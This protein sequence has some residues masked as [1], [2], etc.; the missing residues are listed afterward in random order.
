M[1]IHRHAVT[2]VWKRQLW[3]LRQSTR[4]RIRTRFRTDLRQSSVCAGRLLR[5]KHQRPRPGS[6]LYAMAHGHPHSS[7]RY[8]VLGIG[9][10]TGTEEQ[11]L[12]LPITEVDIIIGKWLA[13]MSYFSLALICSLSN[14]AVLSW[15]GE[16]DLGL[17][18][19]QYFD[20]SWWAQ[21]PL[22]PACSQ[23]VGWGCR[24]S[25]SSLVSSYAVDSPRS[26]RDWNGSTHLTAALSQW[27]KSV[28]H[29]LSRPSFSGS[30]S[31]A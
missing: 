6:K 28:S 13:I 10:G 20:G 27:G 17:V 30:L 23:V 16:P 8:G 3:S 21:C 14:V 9:E 11:L 7:D 29:L 4:V 31:S 12:T 18:F 22:P 25:R 24:R 26:L 15:L 5:S 2:A 19:A 1:S